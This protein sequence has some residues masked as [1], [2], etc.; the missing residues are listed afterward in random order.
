MAGYESVDE[1][2]ERC[3]E[4]ILDNLVRLAESSE[5]T[6]GDRLRAALKCVD[7]LDGFRQA[8]AAERYLCEEP[9]R[10]VYSRSKSNKAA[11]VRGLSPG[12]PY[13]PAGAT[14]NHPRRAPNQRL[15]GRRNRQQVLRAI[16]RV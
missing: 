2:A 13:S 4:E 15:S 12:G 5:G 1:R 7:G 3:E 14:Q 16:E 10:A 9:L 11:E 6:A 8:L